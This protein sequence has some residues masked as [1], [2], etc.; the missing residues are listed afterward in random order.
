MRYYSVVITRADGTPYL[1]KSL[2]NA[3]APGI[4]LSSLLPT[5]PQNPV[6]GL[7]NPAALC[8]ELDIA[9]ANVTKPDSDAGAMMRVWGLG[10]Q[11]IG[12]ASDLNGMD[13]AI[14]A[15]M[16][17]G[18]PLANPA[19]AGLLMQGRI[20]QAFGN[21]IGTDQTIDLI[22]VA[23]GLATGSPDEPNN[24]P[25]FWAAG[26]PLATAIT[27]TLRTAMP[28]L[29]VT[30]NISPNLV[31]NAD[32]TGHYGSLAEF[33][34]MIS[35]VS[36]GVFGTASGYDGVTIVQDGQ[37]ISVYDGDG[38]DQTGPVKAISFADLIGQPTWIAPGTISIKTVLRA[39]IRLNDTISLPETLFTVTGQAFASRQARPQNKLTFSGNFKVQQV[40]HYGHS[41]QPDAAS[42]N[43][44]CQA[45]PV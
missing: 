12:H 22:F 27:N 40:H 16:A 25:F 30:I 28:G 29:P 26:T 45:T 15:G 1:F 38:P 11:D 24:F 37:T 14:Y 17:K 34:D 5:G 32:Q 36:I 3:F 43:T 31:M 13:I 41:R 44:T 4:T 33:A 18:L 7:T 6:S 10:L 19:Q 42:W 9:M 20:Y 8:V 35:R 23:G 21:W 39:D 2:G